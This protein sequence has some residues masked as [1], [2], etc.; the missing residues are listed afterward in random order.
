MKFDI[1][2]RWSGAVQFS[3][4]IEA[5]ETTLK[6]VK[7]GLAVRWAIK[8]GA[9]LRDADLRGADLRRADLTRADLTR[10]DLRDAVLRD[11]DLRGA[12]LTRADLTR[13]DLTRADLTDADIPFIPNIDAAVLASI[14]ANKAAKKNGLKMTKWH[15]T[16]DCNETNWCETTHCRAGYVICLAGAA[17]FA[18]ERKIGPAAAGAL[19]YARSRPGKRVPN[20]YASD[21]DAMAS[22]T[23]DAAEAQQ[24]TE[25]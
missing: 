22:I 25:I 6:S 14:E 19:I 15:G 18:L 13:A 24:K 11:A 17:G 9:V 23:A 7:I 10:A 5:D 21:A 1:L 20:F 12:D 4:E 2:N 16:D 3:A 8:T